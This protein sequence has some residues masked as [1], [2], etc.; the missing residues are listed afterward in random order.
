MDDEEPDDLELSR[1]M[2]ADLEE[3]NADFQAGMSRLLTKF[4]A[5]EDGLKVEAM[6]MTPRTFGDDTPLKLK[7]AIY[8]PILGGEV[9]RNGARIASPTF[10][11][12]SLDGAIKA[13]HLEGKIIRG[14]M[15]VTVKALRDWL[16]RG[17]P[18]ST[19]TPERPPQ[20]SAVRENRNQERKIASKE[21]A[22]SMLDDLLGKAREKKK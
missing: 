2:L 5:A 21:N 7:D 13:G 4:H 6:G 8:L 1:R 16:E 10:K 12:S 18:S 22:I 17:A 20:T 15:T 9:L 11:V 3:L 19:S 14:K